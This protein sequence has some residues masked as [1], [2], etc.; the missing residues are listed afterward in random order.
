MSQSWK[1]E[2]HS[3]VAPYLLVDDARRLIA[4]LEAVFDARSGRQFEGP[5]GAI[6]HAEVTIAD[7][8][9]MMGE[10]TEK[11]KAFPSMV[12]VYVPDVDAIYERALSEGGTAKQAP[13][14]AEGDPDRRGGFRDPSGN[15]WW[16][17]T[18]ID[19]D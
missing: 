7:S 2:G 15:I 16:I 14:N 11:W 10:A 17:S 6:M 8:V 12:H 18:Q 3:T 1:P 13:A 19:G 9:V 5:D 4:F